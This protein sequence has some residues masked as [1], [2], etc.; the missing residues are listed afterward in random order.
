MSTRDYIDGN[1]S[2]GYKFFGPH[3]KDKGYI[4]RLYAPNA[5][6][7]YL[8]GDFNDWQKKAMRKY[9]TGV[10]SLSV[11]NAKAN[12]SYMYTI[13]TDDGEFKKIDPFSK[14]ISYEEDSSIIVENSYKFK[15]KKP[16]TKTKNILQVH[17]ASLFKNNS[18]PGQIYDRLLAYAKENKY[19]SILLMPINEYQNYKSMGYSPLSLFSFSNR[20]GSLY[21][22]ME[23]IDKAHKEKIQVIG[24]ID[25]SQFDPDP[26]GLITYD[27]SNVYNY[28]YDDI[29]YNYYG[30]VNFDPGKNITRSYIKSAI[31]L[32]LDYY[33]LDGVS[34]VSIDNMIYWQAD[35]NRGVNKK[36]TNFIKDLVDLIKD[37][38]SLALASY[39]GYYQGFDFGFDLVF[40]NR[41]KSLVHMLKDLPINRE[42]YK[43]HILRIIEETSYKNLLGF[44]YL[45]STINEASVAMKM[46]SNDKKGDQFKSLLTFLY[47][48]KSPKMLFMGDDFA[49]L[50]TFSIYDPFSFTKKIE[51]IDHVND[52]YK[53]VA[54]LYVETKALSDEDSKIEVLDIE[55][56][57]LYAYK[58]IYKDEVYLVIVNFT[59]L[60]YQ[61][62]SPY[63]LDELLNTNDL[64]YGGSGNINGK[65]KMGDLINLQGFSSAIFKLNK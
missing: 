50:K 49:N 8:L 63:D 27:G 48:Q 61:I 41:S 58:K 45:D 38:N 5:K 11:S 20:H 22:F 28:D 47:S 21:D 6:K 29:T 42:N 33:K 54:K 65:L 2:E 60:D 32:Y 57:S 39:N 24:E 1:S 53:D 16:S 31:S 64:R 56:Y 19:T 52:Y 10:F 62:E 3:K 14:E 18:K 9:K 23:F 4:F 43:K 30:S 25:I 55:G 36:W 59:D 37:K 17:L 51:R 34:L 15:H 46:Y 40:D 35:S 13:Q 26:T 7:V 12:D 44:T